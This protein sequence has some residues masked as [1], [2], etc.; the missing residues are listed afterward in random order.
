MA[1]L[2]IDPGEFRAG[3]SLQECRTIYDE[4][5][6]H[7]EEWIETDRVF[8]K[9]EP[10]NASADFVADQTVETVTHRIYLRWQSGL[11]SGM[12]LVKDDRKFEVSTVHDPDE[13]GRYLVCGAMEKGV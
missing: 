10:L 9:I 8:G 7:S 1:T 11:A 5:G 12:R 13:T 3:L 6:G 2:N 4:T